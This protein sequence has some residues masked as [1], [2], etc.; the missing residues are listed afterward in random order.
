M[1]Q[2]CGTGISVEHSTHLTL[3]I[4]INQPL[5]EACISLGIYREDSRGVPSNFNERIIKF[6]YSTFDYQVTSNNPQYA[7]N[8]T[9]VL[10]TADIIFQRSLATKVFSGIVF[11]S[12]WLITYAVRL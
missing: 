12:N 3:Q 10:W 1:P 7:T 2:T 6:M 11:G 5:W 9:Q 4:P 8:F